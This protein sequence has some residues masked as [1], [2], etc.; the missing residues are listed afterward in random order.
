[1][2]MAAS[3][4]RLLSL[5]ARIHDVEYQAQMIQN[6]KLNLATQEDEVYRKYNEA[7]DATTLTFQNI[8]GS[9][10]EASF[11]NLCGLGSIGNDIATNKKYVFRDKDDNLIVPNEVYEGYKEFAKNGNEDPYAFAMYMMGV[12]VTSDEGNSAYVDAMKQYAKDMSG[13]EYLSTLNETIH[14]Y[15]DDIFGGEDSIINTDELKNDMYEAVLQG[16]W[17]TIESNLGTNNISDTTKNKLDTLKEKMDEFRHKAF[18]RGDGAAEVYSLLTGE[19]KDSFDKDKFQYYLRWGK[20]IQD[21]VGLRYCTPASIYSE[22]FENNSSFLQD[23]LQAGYITIDTVDTNSKTGRLDKNTTSVASDSTL[24]YTTTSNINK[25][26]LA[27]AEAEYEHAM[28]Q[29]DRKDKQYDM[30]L[31]RLETE[32]SALTTEFDSV[33]KVI[34]DNIQR[35]FKIFS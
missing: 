24:E 21:E 2:G 6:A 23:M 17:G 28:K 19:E 13:S 18:S 16:D 30:S 7:L 14:T 20:L 12:D 11:N 15:L 31:T 26:E 10:I 9:R 25:K 4:A 33:K 1:M 29:I 8:Q 3:Q 22:D 27:K 34:D 35:T 32:R 5:T